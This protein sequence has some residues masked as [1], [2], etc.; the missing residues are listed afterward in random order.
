MK[1]LALCLIALSLCLSLLTIDLLA[2]PAAAQ[3]PIDGDRDGLLS[4]TEVAGWCNGAG[5]FVTDP[6]SADSDTDG[7]SDGE[8]QLFDSNPISG[9]SPGIYVVYEDR[10]MTGDYFPWQPYGHKLIARGDTLAAPRSDADSDRSAGTHAVVVRRGTTFSVGGAPGQS[11]TI[12]NSDAELTALSQ[13]WDAG[14]NRW[15]V[16]IP[17]GGSVGQYTLKL[18]ASSLDLFVIFEIPAATDGLSDQAIRRFLYDNVSVLAYT[19]RFPGDSGGPPYSI[20]KGQEVKEGRTYR[21]QNQQ[22]DRWLLEDYVMP[23]IRGKTDPRSAANALVALVDRET[24]FRNPR[25]LTSSWRVLHPGSNPR[26]QCSNLGGLMAAFARAAGIPA[27]PVIIDRR[28][29]TFDTSAEVWVGGTWRVYRGYKKYE[30]A[31]D[32]LRKMGCSEP[33]WPACGRITDLSR[34]TWGSRNYAPW[35]SGGNG[36]GNVLLLGDEYWTDTGLAYRWASW[37]IDSIKLDRRK[38]ATQNTPYWSGYGW[39]NE[40]TNTGVPGWPSPPRLSSVLGPASDS[41]S[42]PRRG[43][44]QIGEVV[45]EYG[46][47]ANRNG[48]YDQLVLDVEVTIARAGRYWLW[49]QLHTSDPNLAPGYSDGI[50]AEA[51]SQTELAAGSQIVHLVFDGQAISSSRANAPYRLRSLRIVQADEPEPEEL[52]AGTLALRED[53]YTM[54]VS[55]IEAFETYGAMLVDAYTY[56]T[57]DTNGDGRLDVLQ[58]TSGVNIYQPGN[59]TV[60]GSLYDGREKLI[61]RATWSGAGS[62]VALRFDKVAGTVGPYTLRDLELSNAAGE[63]I[64]YLAEPY[65]I[66]AIPALTYAQ[67]ASFDLFVTEA[68]PA[69]GREATR[70]THRFGEAIVAGDLQFEA[71]VNVSQPD[72]Y[73][74]AGW[75]VDAQGN[76]ITW[77]TGQPAQLSPGRQTL[78]LTFNGEGIR[79]HAA[80]GPYTVVALKVLAGSSNIVLDSVD[81]ALTTQPYPISQLSER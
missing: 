74:L 50:I 17:A 53:L 43:G 27:R 33:A 29:S 62:T 75:L 40:P 23:A 6:A 44:I 55:R 10:F 59:Y 42:R 25:P 49:G 12:E 30:M 58:V 78:T 19:R 11:L 20:P 2:P 72:T 73:R 54:S 67:P 60:T 63:S 26:Q 4:E 24:V 31:L 39:R 32:S 3:M 45:G 35:H 68:S 47:D 7:L 71:E 5:C 37:D 21:F 80:D 51:L 16:S 38:L 41:I 18:G 15:Q 65:T 69:D 36:N 56:E 48:Q 28:R 13:A 8:E 79:A 76:L 81:I 52:L 9:A 14:A 46:V 57:L 66:D 70:V 22:Y 77:A 61:G 64:D 34:S 1:Q